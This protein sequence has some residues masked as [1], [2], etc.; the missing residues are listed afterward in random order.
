MPNTCTICKHEQRA[1]IESLLV[2]RV[3]LRNI[4][5]QFGL[6]DHTCLH[7]HQECI[8]ELLAEARRARESQSVLNVEAE[9]M[10]YTITMRKLRDACD[11]WLSDPDRIGEYTLDARADEIDVVYEISK[12]DKVKR[13][14]AALSELIAKV[15]KQPGLSV[16]KVELKQADPRQLIINTMK[17]LTSQLDVMAKLRGLYKQPETNPNDVAREQQ[18]FE[19]AVNR[20][21]AMSHNRPEGPYS[22]EEAEAIIR[23]VQDETSRGAM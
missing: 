21:I 19:D 20:L 4:A 15:E 8:A 22:R 14:R 11:R 17:Q 7:R 3:S 6:K 2:R 13:E 10:G 18:Q 23:R 16:V 9:L 1:E 12:G 5:Q